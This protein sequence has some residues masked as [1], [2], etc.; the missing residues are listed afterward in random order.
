MYP[1]IN[2]GITMKKQ[3]VVAGLLSGVVIFVWLTF[4][5]AILPFKRYFTLLTFPDQMTVHQLLKERIT[6]PGI[7]T[8][9]YFHSYSEAAQFEGYADEPIFTISYTGVT[10][11]T[12]TG[13]LSFSILA[14]FIAPMI[15][16]WMLS[17]ASPRILASYIRRTLFVMTLGIF[18]AVFGDWLRM[19]EENEPSG[20]IVFMMINHIIT[21]TLAG[22][23]IAWRIKPA[24]SHS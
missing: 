3:I 24:G 6:E 22:L 12:V 16:S 5:N 14:L 15:A 8:C 7:Y 18:L 4:S 11:N 2:G 19:L 10:H 20:L 13:F 1:L 9:P 21:W 23:I 17:V